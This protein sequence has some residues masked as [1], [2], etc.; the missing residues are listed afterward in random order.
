MPAGAYLF[1]E[2]SRHSMIYLRMRRSFH[3]A[4]LLTIVAG[5]A[6]CVS[7]W[8]QQRFEVVA[9]TVTGD[10]ALDG[11]YRWLSLD[12][13]AVPVEFPANSG[14]RLV[15]GTLDLREAANARAASGSYAMRFTEQPVNDTLRTTGNDGRFTLRGDTIQ[16]MP[17]GQSS[18]VI[19]RFAWRPNGQLVLT[20]QAS[21]VWVY[22]RR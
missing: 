20:D 15:Y 21:H 16:F 3:L 17:A 18:A 9:G 10:S 13:K 11:G 7:A 4:S 19:F 8:P 14:R 22:A 6:A 2:T 5:A 1:N 12:G